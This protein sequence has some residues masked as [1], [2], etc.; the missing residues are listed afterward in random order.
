M[1]TYNTHFFHDLTN[2]YV[3][4]IGTHHVDVSIKKHKTKK[5]EFYELSI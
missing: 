2:H 5:N 4:V 3:T 1:F